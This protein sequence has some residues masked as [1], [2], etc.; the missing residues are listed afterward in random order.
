MRAI[1]TSIP[2]SKN[3]A[4]NNDGAVAS[5]YSHYVFNLLCVFYISRLK[6][7]Y[8]TFPYVRS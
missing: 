8:I 5:D 6:S 2:K 4:S 1:T 7:S 3:D